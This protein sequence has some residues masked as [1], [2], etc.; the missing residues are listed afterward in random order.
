MHASVLLLIKFGTK[1]QRLIYVKHGVRDNAQGSKYMRNI[2]FPRLDTDWGYLAF[3]HCAARNALF[4]SS[5]LFIIKCLIN[6]TLLE[7]HITHLKEL[8]LVNS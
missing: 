6:H 4:P 1:I 3:I 7:V 5:L 8:L 2:I